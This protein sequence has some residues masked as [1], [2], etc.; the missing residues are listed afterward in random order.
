MELVDRGDKWG[1]TGA[2]Y[3]LSRLDPNL[4]NL[5]FIDQCDKIK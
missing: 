4:T 5:K 3:D 2:D 1:T